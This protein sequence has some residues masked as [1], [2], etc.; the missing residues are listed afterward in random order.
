MQFASKFSVWRGDITHLE[1]DAIVN[2][3]N[4]GLLG[5]GGVDGATHKAA[6]PLYNVNVHRFRFVDRKFGR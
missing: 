1:I 5:G 2:S 3:A 4:E 6:G